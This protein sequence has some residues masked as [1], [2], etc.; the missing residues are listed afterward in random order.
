MYVPTALLLGVLL[1]EVWRAGAM[2]ATIYVS[3]IR[4]ALPLSHSHTI[5][6]G[7]VTAVLFAV[8]SVAPSVQ[9]ESG[10]EVASPLVFK[11]AL[12]LTFP[13]DSSKSRKS[14]SFFV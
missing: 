7:S 6:V 14:V 10:I 11:D 1:S 4:S 3:L 12:L 8:S 5:F 9:V 13:L 2:V